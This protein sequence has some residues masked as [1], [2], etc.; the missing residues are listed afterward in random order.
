MSTSTW[1]LQLSNDNATDAS[2]LEIGLA[3]FEV[4]GNGQHLEL[5][6]LCIQVS[7]KQWN[8]RE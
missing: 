8:V 1:Q 4:Q 5:S 7:T 2:S 3:L 6:L